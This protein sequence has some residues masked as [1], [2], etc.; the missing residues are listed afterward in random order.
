MIGFLAYITISLG[1][2]SMAFFYYAAGNPVLGTANLGYAAI[3][4]YLAI[5]K[6]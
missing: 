1:L 5:K 6:A 4:F 3:F 2:L